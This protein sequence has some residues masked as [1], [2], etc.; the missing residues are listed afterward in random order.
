MLRSLAADQS[1]AVAVPAAISLVV[2]LGFA[3]LGSE[4]A[5]WYVVRRTMQGAADSA[6]YSAA[7]A[8]AANATSTVYTSEATSVAG[9]Y[10]FV[11]GTA[12][13]TIAVNSPPTHGTHTTDST[14]VEVVITRPQPLAFS[15]LFLKTS[16]TLTARAVATPGATGCVLALDRGNVTDVSDNGNTTLNLVHC[17]LYVNSTSNSALSLVGQA[18]INANAAYIS[19]NYSL[20]GQAALNTTQGTHTHAAA[21]N[22]PYADVQIPAYHG[23]D[24][25]GYSITGGQTKTF[26]TGAS[27]VMVFCNGLSISGGSRV[28]VGPGVYVIDRGSLS[29]SGNS[30]LTGSASGVTF[31]FTSSTGSNY[32]T[33][34]ISGGSTVTI[35]APTSGPLAGLAFFQDRNAPTSGS[36]SFSGG[37]NQNITGAVYFPN[38]NVTFNGGTVTGGAVCTQLVAYTITFNGNANFNS[39]CAGTGARGIGN[40]LVQLTE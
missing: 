2:L 16:P 20:S 6:A 21:T 31:V 3:G 5:S 34:S 7:Y 29:I 23:C 22:D 8:K 25:T 26:S 13:V 1:G 10:G 11:D 17:N 24:Q 30:S 12:G 27:G 39:N 19:G 9:S 28:T 4:V 35:A 38:Q 40:S 33:V 14:A 37:T 32:A 15:A 18:T 36:N